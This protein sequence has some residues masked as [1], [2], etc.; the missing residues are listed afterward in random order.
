MSRTRIR[1]VPWRAASAALL[2]MGAVTA[3][4]AAEPVSDG[5]LGRT[6]WETLQRGG[7]VMFI[8]LALSVAG[9]AVILE[10]AFRTRRGAMLPASVRRALRPESGA[11]D[12]DAVLAAP[13]R[14]C[15]HRILRA[16]QLWRNGTGEQVQAAI[17]EAVD[18]LLWRY[19]RAIRPLGIIA[20]TA[21]LLGLLGTVIGIIEAFD[22]V[23]RQG[24]LGDPAALASGISKA[25]LTTCFGLIVAIPM[26]LGYHYF[27]GRAET[28]LRECEELAKELL[29]LPPQ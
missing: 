4:D 2:M 1:S 20:S 21:P 5:V 18:H 15:V 24:A 19:R 29:I 8:I 6:A 23:A 17:E 16:G 11:A 22:V 26:L 12:L 13:P 28:L 10:L 7:V 9:V 14:A 27:N 3:L 25:L